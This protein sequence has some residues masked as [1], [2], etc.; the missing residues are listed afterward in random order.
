MCSTDRVV[1]TDLY[2][3]KLRISRT[4]RYVRIAYRFKSPSVYNFEMGLFG[5]EVNQRKTRQTEQH[6]YSNHAA[7]KKLTVSRHVLLVRGCVDKNI[8]KC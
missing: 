1:E 7:T 8:F 3:Y 5:E 4:I 2:L 6:V